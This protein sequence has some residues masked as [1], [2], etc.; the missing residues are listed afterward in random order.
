MGEPGMLTGAELLASKPEDA[1]PAEIELSSPWMVSRRVIS[2][3]LC[4]GRFV[5]I[6]GSG[7]REV[8]T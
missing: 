5:L 8:W 1:I 3:F 4:V 2:S 6:F 7:E